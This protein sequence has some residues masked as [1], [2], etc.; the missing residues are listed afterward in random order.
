[1]SDAAAES[2]SVR[3]PRRP[4]RGGRRVLTVLG[5]I[6]AVLLVL[7]A[8]AWL[9]RRAA[10]RQVLI[11]WLEQKGID[12][13]MDVE[14]VELDGL[15]ASIR[16][17]DP[18]NPDVVVERV[19]V[20]YVLGAP[21]SKGGLGVTPS[22][23]RLVRP[24]VRASVKGGKLSLGSL[25]P[26]IEEF[27]G[28]PPRPDSRGPLVI[29]EA[30]RVRLDTD[31]GPANL[32][33]DARIDDGKLMRL[34]ARMPTTAF[35]SG[36]D[37][38]ARGLSAA[39]EVTT[40]GDRVA[41]SVAAVAE[42]A[43]VAGLSGERARLTLTGDLPYPDMK[44]RRG[45]GQARLTGALTAGRLT[46]GDID[47]RD[48]AA[49]LGFEGRVTGW[50]EAFRV[51][52]AATADLRAARLDGPAAGSGARLRLTGAAVD[53]SR[54][55]RGGLAWRVEGPAALTAARLSGAG[56]DGSGVAL[57]SSRLLIGGHDA[58]VEANGALDLA[59]DRL[60]WDQMTLDGARGAA[61]L[62]LVVDGGVRLDAAGSLRAARGAWPLFGPVA[63]DD[64][65]ELAEMKRALSAF[66]V[67]VPAF[68]VAS[69]PSGSRVT[70]ARPATL[71]PANGGVLTINPAATPI[72][73]APTGSLG[74]GALAVV[75]TRGQGL[76]EA[77]F[78][79]P[80][81]SLTPS[82][83]TA[84]LDGRA[85]LDFGLARG[86]ALTTRGELASS[87]GRLTYTA[88][89][90]IPLTVE[91][92]ELD[93]SDVLNVAGDFC[94]PAGPLV[95]VTDGGWRAEGAF[96]GVK[97]SAPFLAMD[98]RDAEGTLVANGGPRGVGMEA[99]VARAQAVDTT[100]PVRF[101]PLTASGSAR[102]A[103]DAWTGAFD[104][105]HGDVTLGRLT[106]THDGKAE[107]GGLTIDAP[108]VV[109]A[110]NG[111][112]PEAL[113]PLAA[114]FIGS[115]AVGRIGFQGRIGWQAGTEGSSSGRLTVD[116][117]D[118]AS[119]AGPV[120]GLRGVLD[121]TSLTP[122]VTAP[123]QR[124]TADSL[125]TV[126]PLTG[127]DV[128]FG[129]DASTVTVGG[130]ELALAG[131]KVRIEPLSIPLDRTL[132]VTGV[133]VLENVQLGQIIA[134]A[135]FGDKVDLDAVVSGRLPFTYDA[136]QGV[137]IQGGSLE[138]VQPGRLSIK[139]EALT[140]LEAGGAGEGV[141]PGTVEDLAYQAMENLAFDLLSAQVNSLDAGRIG[142]IFHIKGRHDPPQR[143]ELRVPVSELISRAF[144]NRNLPLPS[145]TGIDLTLDTTLNV[146]ELVA[147]L[148]A[149]NRARNGEVDP[150]PAA[151]PPAAAPEPAITP[152]P[153]P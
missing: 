39:V 111:L 140:G 109:F 88:A 31:Y 72:F 60:G 129:V 130:G 41:L 47:A 37:L 3:P 13:D 99:R 115:P 121:F 93:E 45:D 96:R 153:L 81:W 139:R 114:D 53:M 18:R 87:G 36:D 52:G 61:S 134:G 80:R 75:A 33:A 29:V 118:F 137:R 58:A 124:L 62:D 11:G 152:E 104:L 8:A 151:P 10:T 91:R 66:A 5:V 26:L 123:N 85:A 127:I 48:A 83:F 143:Q 105:A 89:G 69:G 110:E 126:A 6:L 71:R 86:I 144:L 19:E 54:D 107:A 35:K 98:F 79:I 38:D 16:I 112:Q 148:M 77:A 44:T 40:T 142:L 113:S 76:P 22:R 34:S 23:I 95:T 125:E 15:V 21:W 64:L 27:T 59:A 28:K 43:V 147:D 51:Q 101:N 56:L 50:I 63:G 103:G 57:T 116:G 138:A 2:P 136:V 135:G 133:L 46:A 92:L 4:R 70:L 119:P 65:P 149:L 24:V 25:D 128:T 97:A 146:N 67:D 12:A 30:A 68:R 94:P 74:G 102:L 120:K 108:D 1:M 100:D 20:D 9:N 82:G 7:A 150:V 49:D 106:L 42:R 14:R 78:A 55:A 141:P 117:L 90:C 145:D 32:L 122:L 131:G 73:A 132:P 17:G 84:T